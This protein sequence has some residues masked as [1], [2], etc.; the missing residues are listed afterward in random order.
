MAEGFTVKHS[1]KALARYEMHANMAEVA[2]GEQGSA[3]Q[4]RAWKIKLI[5][6]ENPSGVIWG[7]KLLVDHGCRL[8]TPTYSGWAWPGMRPGFPLSRE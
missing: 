5:E 4:D 6:K 8:S 1:T 7:R 2:R 3:R